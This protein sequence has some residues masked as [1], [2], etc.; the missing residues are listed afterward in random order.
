MAVIQISKIQVRRGQR[1]VSGVPQLSSAEFAWAVDT[2]ELFIGN[3]SVA[4]G[5]P[6]VGNTK[7]LTEHDNILDLAAGYR[8]ASTDASITASVERSI[9]SKLDEY[10]SVLDFGAVPDGS[11]DCTSAFETAFTQLFKNPDEKYQK[12]LLVPNGVYL[13]ASTLSIP[14]NVILQGETKNGAVLLLDASNIEF[15]T[16]DGNFIVDATNRPSNIKIS[17]LTISRSTGQVNLTGLANSVFDNV[18]FLGEYVLSSTPVS[19]LTEPAA[20]YWS[21]SSLFATSVTG[22]KF[23]SCD[24]ESNSISVK[25]EQSTAYNTFVDFDR[26]NF[27]VGDTA[28]YINGVSG[29]G[30]NWKFLDCNFEEIA[31]HAFRSTNGYSTKFLQTSF[32]NCGNGVGTAGSPT[33]PIVSFGEKS[34]NILINCTSNRMQSVADVVSETK[35]GYPVAENSDKTILVDRINKPIEPTDSFRPIVALSALNKYIYIDY[36]AHFMLIQNK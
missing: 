21:N 17:N 36:N 18:K 1:N 8:F 7:I 34:N 6:Y 12:V 4:E 22:I 11:T 28:V 9:G 10:V 13:F 20:L 19:L 2:Q 16:T 32:K 3:G 30:N 33:S 15:I 23:T 27:F 29:Q 35:L 24:F 26:C 14:S 5:A 31:N 25:C